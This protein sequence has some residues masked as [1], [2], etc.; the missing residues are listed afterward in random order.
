LYRFITLKDKE[1]IK[2][3]PSLTIDP[4]EEENEDILIW[5]MAQILKKLYIPAES[6]L[7]NESLTGS[8]DDA[9]EITAVDYAPLRK[10]IGKQNRI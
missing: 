7:S 8:Q 10:E 1:I 4:T 2:R 6:S 9:P 3:F 5:I